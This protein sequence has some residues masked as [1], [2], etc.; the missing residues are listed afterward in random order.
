MYYEPGEEVYGR[1]GKRIQAFEYRERLKT[2]LVETEDV[3]WQKLPAVR[4]K[5]GSYVVSVETAYTDSFGASHTDEG[6]SQTT[7]WKIAL[8]EKE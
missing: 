7:E 6:A 5:D 1:D 2:E 4:R 8:K 3:R